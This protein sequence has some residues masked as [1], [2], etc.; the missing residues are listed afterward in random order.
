MARAIAA[1]GKSERRQGDNNSWPIEQLQ[2]G[3]VYVVAFWGVIVEV[4]SAGVASRR[5]TRQPP[6]CSGHNGENGEAAV[7]VYCAV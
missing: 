2:P 6:N 3:D 7:Q 4:D 1:E 5:F